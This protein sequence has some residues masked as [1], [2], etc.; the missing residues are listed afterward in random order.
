MLFD[1]RGAGRRTTVKGVYLMLALLMGGGLILFGI[2][3]DVSGGLVD[4]ITERGATTDTGTNRYRER[5]DEAQRKADANPK[6]AA[7]WAAVARAR[8][9]LAGAGD[10][11]DQQTGQFTD[12]GK[13]QLRIATQAW[14]RSVR[15][16][17]EHP[18]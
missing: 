13:Q 11:F 18:G 1:L 14:E 16:A 9:Q 8:Y 2:G 12:A 5:V 10:Y 3:G 7:A 17:G 6:D 4:A 15:L